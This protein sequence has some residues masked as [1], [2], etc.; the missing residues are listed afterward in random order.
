MVLLLNSQVTILFDEIFEEL[1]SF[2]LGENGVIGVLGV[3]GLGDTLM[4][5]LVGV[6]GEFK[7]FRF[8]III[9]EELFKDR[10]D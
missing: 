2:L 6:R 7:V 4:D 5:I 1:E 10:V 8:E 3:L 9:E